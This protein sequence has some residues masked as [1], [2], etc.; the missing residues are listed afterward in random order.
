[1]ALTVRGSAFYFGRAVEAP[2]AA[3]PDFFRWI[4]QTGAG[5]Q[6]PFIVREGDVEIRRRIFCDLTATHFYGIFLSARNTEFQHF[7]RRENGRVIIEAISTAGNPP[8]EMNF[9]AMRMDS[10]K[11][12]FSHYLGSYRFQQ[13]LSDLWASYQNFV[14]LKKAETLNGLEGRAAKAVAE[15][16][17]LRG[18]CMHSPL[19]T[20]GSFNDLVE[21]LGTMSELRMTTYDVE[22]P[23]DRPV[24]NVL[25]SVHRVYRFDAVRVDAG[26]RGWLRDRRSDTLHQLASGRTVYNGSV[27]GLHNDGSP[28]SIDFENS[29]E[30][31]LDCKYDDI[32][33]FELENIA[34]HQ[35]IRD[36][37]NALDNRI[38]FRPAG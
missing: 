5:V 12:L 24:S 19:Y 33:T 2:A 1:M 28:F 18:R 30:N 20:P 29:L 27:I 35:I 26:I 6:W 3:F 11:G 36:M 9:F 14:Q 37:L 21:R 8:I 16:F 17:S 31:F 7:V 15:A 23:A 32:G 34:D 25:K 4:K 10:N 13:F 38:L 22:D